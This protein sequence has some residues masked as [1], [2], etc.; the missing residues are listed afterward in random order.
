M[1]RT[2]NKIP[3]SYFRRPKTQNFRKKLVGTNEE[4]QSFGVA[5]SNRD[6]SFTSRK[7]L[8]SDWYDVY[9]GNY[10]HFKRFL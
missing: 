10:G 3:H 4:L 5:P 9:F 2:F 1:A 7:G 8:V 6:K